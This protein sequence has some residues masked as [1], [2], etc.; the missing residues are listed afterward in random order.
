[1][2]KNQEAFERELKYFEPRD[3][4]E[5]KLLQ[6]ILFRKSEISKPKPT[7]DGKLN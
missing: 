3:A 6:G 1:M 5:R 4:F 7:K 2:H